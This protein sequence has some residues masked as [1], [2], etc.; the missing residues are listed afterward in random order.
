MIFIIAWRNIWRNYGRSFVVI[1]SIIVG[2]WS[3]VFLSG[4]MNGFMA[5]FINNAVRHE[6][7]NIQIHHPEFKE[8]Y[9]IKYFIED[10]N[11]V[12]DKVAY[13]PGIKSVTTRS[14]TNGM[15]SSAKKATGVQIL[16]INP[17][18]EAAVTQIDLLLSEGKYFEGVKRNPVLIGEKL[19]NN[20]NA[21]VRS[22]LVLTFQDINGNI[23][24][25]AFRV[26]G[27]LKSSSV[28]INEATAYVQQSDLNKLLEIGD[29]IH[30]I[31]V[32]THSDIEQ[33]SIKSQIIANN[34]TL[35]T[36]DWKEL[37]PILNFMTVW[38]DMMLRV[39]IVIV[40]MAL[41]FGIVNTMLMSVLERFKELGILMAVGMNKAKVFMMILAETLMLA[42]VGGP[43][44]MLAGYLTMSYL[45]VDGID[46]TD[47]SEALSA[48]GYESIL[49]PKIASYIYF[50]I[51]VGVM[52][53]SFLGAL[54]PAWKAVTLKPVDA[55]AKI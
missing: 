36:E 23:T 53:T 31:A 17:S 28:K 3:L 7:S 20:L 30:E 11:I 51:A 13:L 41:A 55:I 19:A 37:A 39:L 5:G 24:A 10:G 46:L 12:A 33:T 32:T 44:G 18:N 15:I 52:I 1:G 45:G 9:E 8:D 22:K 49:Y 2:M 47:Y 26:V 27:I 25:G 21:K 48:I 6:F 4:F 34:P 50:E 14:I 43:L 29:E 42:L 38:F 35:L 16:G 54:Y 40:M